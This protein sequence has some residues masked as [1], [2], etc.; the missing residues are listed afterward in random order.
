MIVP[1]VRA[2]R[3]RSDTKAGGR[4]TGGTIGRAAIKIDN[5]VGSRHGDPHHPNNYKP[6]FGRRGLWTGTPGRQ[7]PTKI[8]NQVGSRNGGSH[9]PTS[10]EPPTSDG[11][12]GGAGEWLVTVAVVSVPLAATDPDAG[13]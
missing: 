4:R 13:R 7:C 2:P 1:L 12:D 9:H 5:Q 10:H 8:D 3:R 11:R 6:H